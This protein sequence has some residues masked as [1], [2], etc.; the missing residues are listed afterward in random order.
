[1]EALQPVERN[2]GSSTGAQTRDPLDGE[3]LCLPCV[4]LMCLAHLGSVHRNT[5]S[6]WLKNVR[7][8]ATAVPTVS[9]FFPKLIVRTHNLLDSFFFS[10][11]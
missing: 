5:A 4:Q 9:T 8:G 11:L 3:R 2:L 6:S 7:A 10:D 1:M